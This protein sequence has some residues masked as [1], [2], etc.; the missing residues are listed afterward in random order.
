MSNIVTSHSENSEHQPLLKTQP[1]DFLGGSNSEHIPNPKRYLQRKENN[2]FKTLENKVDKEL[3]AWF[4]ANNL[5][6][7]KIQVV[8]NSPNLAV[9]M[10]SAK[11]T[12]A[13][14]FTIVIFEVLDQIK[15][16]SFSLCSK[17]DNFCRLDGR[18]FAKA[19]ALRLLQDKGLDGLYTYP[20][21]QQAQ[22]YFADKP[23]D[24]INQSITPFKI[25]N[26][27]VSNFIKKEDKTKYD[28]GSINPLKLLS[29]DQLLAQAKTDLATKQGLNIDTLRLYTQYI[30]VYENDMF[31]GLLCTT[32]W[33]KALNDETKKLVSNGGYTVYGVVADTLPSEGEESKKEIYITISR[34]S[35]NEQY[36]KELG[37]KQ[38][39]LN[40]S[41]GNY[42]AYSISKEVE[43]FTES[44]IGI[45]QVILK[46]SINVDIKAHS[47]PLQ[48]SLQSAA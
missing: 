19:K 15:R 38:C 17:A 6:L 35:A 24:Q 45:A 34:C 9:C 23:I 10:N 8:H 44:L 18:V 47:Q 37:R 13:N 2:S 46:T 20:M 43:S 42:N 33:F 27:I 32:E 30:R 41:K 36:E 48:E 40:F 28:L 26:W 16:F 1:N 22:D 31:S 3:C 5:P 7:T 4:Q 12:E 11:Y 39:L 29:E 14:G 25:G 21:S